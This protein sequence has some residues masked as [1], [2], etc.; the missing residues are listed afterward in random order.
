MPEFLTAE[1]VID[2]SPD[3]IVVCNQEGIITAWNAGATRLLGWQ[4]DEAIGLTPDQ[5]FVPPEIKAQYSAVM[6]RMVRRQLPEAG[7]R[8]MTVMTRDGQRRAVEF[9]FRTIG[10]SDQLSVLGFFRDQTHRD[11]LETRLARLSLESKMLDEPGLF[12]TDEESFENALRRALDTLC[13]VTGWTVGHALLPSDDEAELL[14]S[15]VWVTTDTD[16]PALKAARSIQSFRP[17]EGIAG[18]AWQSGRARWHLLDLSGE[19]FGLNRLPDGIVA[20]YCLPIRMRN[21][22]IAV[23][24]FFSTDSHPPHVGLETLIRKLSRTLGHIIERREWQEERQRMAAIVESSYDA[25]ISKNINGVITSWN[26]G[27]ERLYGYQAEEVIGE[28]IQIILPEGMTREE[29]EVRAAVDSGQRL[30]QF[31]TRRRRKN[32]EVVNIA[33][34][35][36]PLK[37]AVGHTVGAASIERDITRRK[38][39]QCRLQE[40]IVAAEEANRTKSE[41]LANISHELRT[42]M[43][44][45]LGMTRLALQEKLPDVV[46][47]YLTTARDSADVMLLLINDILDFSRLEASRLELDPA[48]FDIRRTLDDLMALLSLRAHEKGLEL[49]AQVHPQVPSR[50]VGDAKRIRQV[51][52]NLISNAIKFTES[53]EVVVTVALRQNA[54]DP[55]QPDVFSQLQQHAWVPSGVSWSSVPDNSRP[56]DR[57]VGD[58][59]H[60]EGTQKEDSTGNDRDDVTIVFCIADTGIGI[61]PEDHERIFQPFTQVDASTTR[62]YTG[63]GLG[64]SICR[65]LAELMGGGVRVESEAGV[66]SRFYFTATFAA[67]LPAELDLEAEGLTFDTAQLA[68]TPVLI[69]DDNDT[70][71]RFLREMLESWG[72]RA[73]VAHGAED[74]LAR[75]Q[76]ATN[77]GMSFPLLLVDAV[78]PNI[79]GIDLVKEIQQSTESSGATILMLSPADQR[80]FANRALEVNISTLLAK[81]VSQSGLLDAICTVFGGGPVLDSPEQVIEITS[82]PLKVLVAEDIAANRK[83]VE[84][85]LTRRGH[86]VTTAQNGRDAIERHQSETFDAILMDVQ[87]PIMDGMQAVRAIRDSEPSGTHIPIIAM[88]AHAMRGD[89]EACLSAGMDAYISKPLNSA[90]LLQTLESLA[91]RQP[92]SKTNLASLVTR[93]GIW[94]FRQPPEPTDSKRESQDTEVWRPEVALKRMGDD[95]ALLVSMVRY[96]REDSPALLNQ[97]PV[98]IRSGEDVEATRL[99]HSLKGLCANF[100]AAAA[101]KTATSI[102]T[103]CRNQQLD[104][105]ERQLDQLRT[106]IGALDAAL[107][108]WLNGQSGQTSQS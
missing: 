15:P 83:V 8:S 31:E 101:V 84:A 63:T 104:Q 35:I 30:E 103:A 100:E 89:R 49:V 12:S 18:Q 86:S 93:S 26:V 47:D 21:E 61:R 78:M 48:P 45:I 108:T 1:S 5:L 81:P 73:V 106:D 3:A 33:L 22:V 67:A 92:A 59:Q 6:E 40:A 99:A 27:A 32:G 79:D 82:Q 14:S 75:I 54:P 71:C 107:L 69:V 91:Q 23:L 41:F 24:E 10:V 17:G 70:T 55:R 96:F 11:F 72:M 4:A 95:H 19:E 97:L 90:L 39:A 74:A 56:G 28:S 7:Q 50:V 34:T 88:T 76:E 65:E 62:T 42:P 53:G 20:M 68:K 57:V 85:I 77:A 60:A 44:A 9:W 13:E 16:C 51:L 2:A 37:N 105:A 102:E 36:S 38:E 52:T 25:I 29:P 80:L 58:D 64:L 98:A 87:M 66:G 43:N 94:R 46:R